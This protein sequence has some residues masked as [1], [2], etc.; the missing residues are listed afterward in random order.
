MMKREAT[1]KRPS[2]IGSNMLKTMGAR[3]KVKDIP[4]PFKI[5]AQQK[6]RTDRTK[7]GA[8]QERC[9]WSLEIAPNI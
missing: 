4:F 6:R 8:M 5:R 7:C 2:Q 1:T 9:S 3:N